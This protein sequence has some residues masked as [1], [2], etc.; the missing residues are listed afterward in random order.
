MTDT[1]SI[2]EAEIARHYRRNFLAN[3][4]DIAIFMGGYSFVSTTSMLPLFVSRF[5][6]APLIIG[7]VAAIPAVGSLLPQIFTARLVERLPRKKPFVAYTSLMSERLGIII[8]ALVVWLAG[9]LG[10][11]LTLA[12]FLLG[13]TWHAVGTG[14][15]TTAWQEMIAKIIPV[16][17]R[18]RFFGLAFFG[19]AA[20]GLLAAASATIILARYPFPTN[21]AICFTFTAVGAIISWF[22]LMATREPPRHD[23]RPPTSARQYWRNL[24]VLVQEDKN[25]RRYLLSRIGWAF[26]SM[27]SG[28][29]AVYAARRFGLPDQA[30]GTFTT[31]LVASQMVANLALGELADRRGHKVTLELSV[32]A[33]LAAML[34]AFIG[35]TPLWFYVSFA[36]LGIGLA[37]NSLSSLAITMEF[38]TPESRPTYIGLANTTAGAAA[39]IAPLVA[40]WV[41]GWAGYPVLFAVSLVA[42][43]AT[44]FFMRR[45]IREPRHKNP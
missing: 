26:G 6:S 22:F 14:I 43:V 27:G 42:S 39:T 41:A 12:L 45:G 2:V 7:L 11:S 35:A 25:Y 15:L 31:I 21:F 8:M 19:G 16:R 1:D 33:I 23:P 24:L 37:G 5:T 30:A 34:L 44:F 10:A 13:L 40:G 20:L 4:L 38:S 18:G 36:F 17:A 9:G 32:L 28:F 3:V 29:I